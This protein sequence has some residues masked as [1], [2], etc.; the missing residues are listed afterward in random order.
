MWS[1]DMSFEFSSIPVAPRPRRL[2]PGRVFFVFDLVV[3]I[4]LLSSFVSIFSGGLLGALETQ[5]SR[6][7]EAFAL[8]LLVAL[9][10]QFV[11]PAGI[12]RRRTWWTF[13]IIAYLVTE[14]GGGLP[15]TVVTLSESFLAALLISVFLALFQP[16]HPGW[17]MRWVVPVISL[18]VVVIG[19]LPLAALK[20]VSP[21][22]MSTAETWGFL[23]LVAI[24]VGYIASYPWPEVS[25]T[26]WLKAC[27]LLALIV[28][29]VGVAIINPN[30]VDSVAAIGPL[31]SSMVWVQRITEAFIAAFL[32]TG[33]LEVLARVRSP[34]AEREKPFSP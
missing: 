19:E 23:L 6:N 24:L 10:L 32:L 14:W 12:R 33:L 25:S 1:I 20:G 22:I 31:E 30:G 5:I 4:G 18:V 27:W 9:D 21:W 3:T 11:R 29:P 13:L 7:G 16:G 2:T 34:S 26:R 15:G 8:C 28:V 17:R